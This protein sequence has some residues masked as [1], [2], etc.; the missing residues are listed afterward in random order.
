MRPNNL[1]R[2]FTWL[3]RCIMIHDRVWY[4]PDRCENSFEFPGWCHELTFTNEHPLYVEYCS[5]NG[6]WVAAK[7]LANPH[8]NWVAVEK[9]FSRVQKIWSKLKNY[10]LTNLLIIC[11]EG[12]RTTS[13]YFPAS[14][15]EEVYINFPDPW[16]KTRHAKNR[17]IQPAF[18][19]EMH[20]ILKEKGKLTVAT[21]DEAY[22]NRLIEDFNKTNGFVSQ[23]TAP[24]YS[25]DFPNYGTSYFEDLWRQK[26][27][28]IRYH[29]YQKN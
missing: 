1:K 15:I 14:K 11:G 19:L 22:S 10:Q 23:F 6:D 25:L 17:L 18:I 20:R 24:Y 29:I 7:A 9:K 13:Q 28:S 16:P 12:Y 8:Q 3:E 21:D 27:K 2:P 5:G 4:I 26:G